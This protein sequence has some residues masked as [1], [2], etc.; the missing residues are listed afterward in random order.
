MQDTCH[1]II[2]LKFDL[3]NSWWAMWGE[4]SRHIVHLYVVVCFNFMSPFNFNYR[5]SL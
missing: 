1:H 5:I 3:P 4:T 2:C